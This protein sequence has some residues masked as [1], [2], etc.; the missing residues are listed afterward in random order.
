M[1][2]KTISVPNA[3][4]E[5]CKEFLYSIGVTDFKWDKGE[6]RDEE[7]TLITFAVERNTWALIYEWHIVKLTKTRNII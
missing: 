1:K 6:H 4:R 3:K 2:T 7:N 5:E